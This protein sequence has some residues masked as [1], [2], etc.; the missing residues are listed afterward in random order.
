MSNKVSWLPICLLQLC[1]FNK[2]ALLMLILTDPKQ[3]ICLN[4]QTNKSQSIKKT[5]RTIVSRNPRAGRSPKIFPLSNVHRG[6]TFPAPHFSAV[7]QRWHEEAIS[8]PS[9]ACR[10]RFPSLCLPP[11]KSGS[12]VPTSPSLTLTT[13]S[14][15]VQ[16]VQVLLES[17]WSVKGTN[18][19][20]APRAFG[21]E[22][23]DGRNGIGECRAALWFV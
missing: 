4:H 6:R 12:A 10:E 7:K 14:A 3:Q 9:F 11:S 5:A 20:P 2:I 21:G 23:A 8:P 18:A 16:M 1:I 17:F 13:V 22:R 15:S 19:E